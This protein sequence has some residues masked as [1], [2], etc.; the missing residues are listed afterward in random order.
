M[1]SRCDIQKNSKKQTN[2]S[3]SEPIK[4]PLLQ[5]LTPLPVLPV[6]PSPPPSITDETSSVLSNIHE[7]PSIFQ[8]IMPPNEIENL[9]IKSNKR[10]Y[11]IDEQISPSKRSRSSQDSNEK[12]LTYEDIFVNDILLVK[13]DFNQKKQ[14]HAKCIEKNNNKKE[15][16]VHYKGLDSK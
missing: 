10:S 9:P 7:T 2:A 4:Q 6:S 8:T 16:L 3:L 12:K 5:D 13:F 15:L 11:E 1:E 14:Y